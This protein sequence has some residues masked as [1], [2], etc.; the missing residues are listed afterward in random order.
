MFGAHRH[1]VLPRLGRRL[2]RDR[3]DDARPSREPA[4]RTCPGRR[5]V[6][7]DERSDRPAPAGL[8]GVECAD[9]LAPGRRGRPEHGVEERPHRTPSPARADRPPVPS[10]PPPARPAVVRAPGPPLAVRPAPGRTSSLGPRGTSG[11]TS[12]SAVDGA[13]RMWT[14]RGIPTNGALMRRCGAAG[15]S[16][17]RPAGGTHVRNR[18][19]RQRCGVRRSAVARNDPPTGNELDGPRQ[20]GLTGAVGGSAPGG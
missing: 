13:G 10:G 6:E 20:G 11:P 4:V 18:W 8:G 7:Q 1:R 9:D 19:Q 12:W 14:T 5:R 15:W 16:G 3:H 17:V 2:A